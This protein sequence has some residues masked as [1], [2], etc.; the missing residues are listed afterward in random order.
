MFLFNNYKQIRIKNPVCYPL[1][2]LVYIKIEKNN[3]EN[4]LKLPIKF[5]RNKRI[6]IKPDIQ[7]K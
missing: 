7:K 1:C 3:L 2:P 6:L 4:Y 5:M